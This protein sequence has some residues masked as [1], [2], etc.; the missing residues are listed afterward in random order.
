[1]NTQTKQQ[2]KSSTVSK[3]ARRR[4]NRRKA[5][6][7][8]QK[9]SQRPRRQRRPRG[10][11]R[12]A[13]MANDVQLLP[14]NMRND[15]FA[16]GWE[17]NSG[18]LGIGD[19]RSIRTT[20]RDMVIEE[21]EYIGEI[22]VANQPNFNNVAF[23]IN[24]GQATTFPW[25]STIAKNFEKYQFEKLV[26]F[27][28]KE[29]SE[30]ATAGQTGKVI[31]MVDFDA[32]DAPPTTKQQMEDTIPHADAMPSQS[33]S[34]PLAPRDL[35]PRAN[36]AR[37]IRVGGLP[38]NSDIKTYDVGNLNAATI[39]VLANGAVG[40]LHVGYRV[41][42]IKP[43]LE[44]TNSAPANNQVA[45]FTSTGNQTL[46]TTVQ[47]VSLNGTALANGLAIVNTAGSFVPP[48]GNYNIDYSAK[49]SDSANEAFQ[50]STTINK[51]GVNV[52]PI[53]FPQFIDGT[54][55]G[56]TET[57][58]L[59]GSIFVTANGTDAFTEVV[60]A[61]GAAGVLTMSSSIRFTAV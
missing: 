34:L 23:P 57:L 40:E 47:T 25:L 35:A 14:K 49:V 11:P 58:T 52:Y 39:A 53:F 5:A 45:M 38:G 51:N 21:T 37:F 17:D 29:V 36:E 3:S 33:F 16:G 24:P 50:F 26:F 59:S 19:T 60:T 61:T 32:S 54:A 20:K 10:N 30:F 27:Y 43:V 6:A 31:F 41:R 22:V 42:L 44:S 15:P 4:A 2:Q 1:M 56:A 9:V 46:T 13:F 18:M 8:S 7:P 55:L 28:K 48:P 12:S